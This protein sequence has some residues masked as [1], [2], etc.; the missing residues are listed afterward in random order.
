[1]DSRAPRAAKTLNCDP[2]QHLA[3]QDA[4]GQHV[5]HITV[6]LLDELASIYDFTLSQLNDHSPALW[7]SQ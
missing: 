4:Y 3:M 7:L 6:N 5:A 2:D 1:M